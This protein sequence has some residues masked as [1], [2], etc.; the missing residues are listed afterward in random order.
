MTDAGPAP[1]VDVVLA[2]AVRRATLQMPTIGA[3]QVLM[4]DATLHRSEEA[5]ASAARIEVYDVLAAVDDE[6]VTWSLAATIAGEPEALEAVRAARDGWVASELRR[7]EVL[8]GLTGPWRLPDVHPPDA[9]GHPAGAR[10]GYPAPALASLPDPALRLARPSAAQPADFV[11][12]SGVTGTLDWLDPVTEASAWAR[13][14]PVGLDPVGD[15]D[16]R[17]FESAGFR[18]VLRLCCALVRLAGRTGQELTP[19]DV[20]ALSLVDFLFLDE[21]YRLLYIADA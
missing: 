17:T 8:D 12:P 1:T 20:E 2:G 4:A 5:L 15:R 19:E 21:V 7:G 18:A 6:P 10:S 3:T 9:S 14:A 13:W 16:D 11:L